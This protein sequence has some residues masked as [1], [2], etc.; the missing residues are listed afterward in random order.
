VPEQ[1]LQHS[2][3]QDL[4]LQQ[5]LSPQMRQSLDILQA[6]TMELKQLVRQELQTNPALEDES[7]ALSIEDLDESKENGDPELDAMRELADDYREEMIYAGRTLGRN[8][9]REEMRDH[10]YD[11]ISSPLTLQEHLAEQLALDDAPAPTKEAAAWLLGSLD[12]RGFLTEP[13]EELALSAGLPLDQLQKAHSLITQFDPPGV[14]ATDIRQCLLLQLEA[15]GESTTLAYRI[16]N[17]HLDALARN[18][19]PD[20]ARQLGVPVAEVHA[21]AQRISNLNPN[22]ARDFEDSVNRYIHPD[23][24]IFRDEKD[25]WQIRL[26]NEELPRLRIN[27][28][29]KDM[30]TTSRVDTSARTFIRDKIRNGKFII[31]CIEQRQHTIRRIAEVLLDK[32][33]DYFEKGSSHLKP[34][35]MQQVADEVGVHETTVSRAIAGKYAATP[36]GIIDLRRFFASGYQTTNGNDVANTSVKDRIAELIAEEDNLHP[37]SDDRIVS[38]LKEEGLNIARRTVAKYRDALHIPPSHLRKRHG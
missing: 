32:Q 13:L 29:Y 19:R 1:S 27:S 18:K 11:S 4:A 31:Q 8:R 2:Q 3:Y 30:L 22:P 38:K 24:H 33:R 37:Y 26:N 35:T 14:G 28:A 7:E 5:R 20:I 23:L 34:L 15:L 25:Q 36:H 21:A 6:P 9:E 17:D 12:Q 10:L 16:V